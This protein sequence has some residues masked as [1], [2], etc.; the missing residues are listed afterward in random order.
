[1]NSFSRGLFDANAHRPHFAVVDASDPHVRAAEEAYEA[2]NAYLRDAWRTMPSGTGGAPKTTA[3]PADEPGET[4][5]TATSGVCRALIER[6]LAKRLRATATATV[7]APTPSSSS[8]RLDFAWGAAWDGRRGSCTLHGDERRGRRSRGGLSQLCR[9]DQQRVAHV[10]AADILSRLPDPALD[11]RIAA[12]FAEDAES[13]DVSRLLPEVEAAA[14]A[15]DAAAGEARARAF[16]PLLSGDDLKLARAEMEGAT[17]A[18]D[19]LHEAAKKLADRIDA[20]KSLEG[21]RRLQAEHERVSAERDRLAEAME[22][23]ADPI[24]QIAHLV[25][26][27]EACDREIRRLNNATS[28]AKFGH[29]PF[30][31]SEAAP[32]I[33]APGPAEAQGPAN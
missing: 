1:V 31:L 30:V 25:R 13:I 3:P 26:Q 5:E 29:I 7:A 23:M 14:K 24:A 27:I 19:R 33:A 2:R 17:F 10:I 21:D 8:A 32:A 20:L 11:A 16:D 4:R 15:A 18:R 12:A 6:R 22:R 28:T 9:Q